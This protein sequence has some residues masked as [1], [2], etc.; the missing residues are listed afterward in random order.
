MDSKIIRIATWNLGLFSWFKYASTF[1]IKLNGKEVKNEYFQRSQINVIE[2]VIREINADI[3]VLEELYTEEDIDFIFLKF[4][5]L[6]PYHTTVNTWYHKHSIL[7]LSKDQMHKSKLG[8]SEFNLIH[9]ERISFIPIH[10]N[11]F[12]ARKRLSQV[13]SLLK[14]ARDK[15]IDCILGDTNLWN[16]SKKSYFIFNKDKK[17]YKK[18]QEYF[19]DTTKQIGSTSKAGLNFDKIFVRK[20]LKFENPIC[21]KTNGKGMDHYAVFVDIQI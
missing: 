1:G 5:D 12:H 2:E 19:K 13:E 9:T 17:A 16:Y 14:E 3:C 7:M 20:G 8:E 4:K 11:S 18:L 15:R 6:Y 21:I 10:L